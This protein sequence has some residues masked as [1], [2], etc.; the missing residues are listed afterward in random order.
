MKVAAEVSLRQ[1]LMP[2]TLFMA[3]ADNSTLMGLL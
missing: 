2:L 1:K 3:L